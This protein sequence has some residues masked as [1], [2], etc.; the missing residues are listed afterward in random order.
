[1]ELKL[2]LKL[3]DIYGGDGIVRPYQVE[4]VKLSRSKTKTTT[5]SD[6]GRPVKSGI[7]EEQKELKDTVCHTFKHDGDETPRQKLGGYHGKIWGALKECAQTLKDSKGLFKSYAEI[8]RIMKTVRIL[9]IYVKLENINNMTVEPL[10]ITLAN[11]RSSQITQYFDVIGE[12]RVN[13]TLVYPDIY[14]AKI[15]EMLKILPDIPF[16]NK[17]RGTV[18]ILSSVGG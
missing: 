1:M 14:A 16:G 18:E 8:D 6:I 10:P 5:R 13:V 3:H 17:R 12:C 15:A 7:S 9:P 11:Y 2:E 4:E